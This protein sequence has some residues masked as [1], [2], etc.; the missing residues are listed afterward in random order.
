MAHPVYVVEQFVCQFLAQWHH[1]L[2]PMLTIDTKTNGSIAVSYNC[3]VPFLTPQLNNDKHDESRK[4]RSGRR[5]RLRRRKQRTSKFKENLNNDALSSQA[6]PSSVEADIST[7]PVPFSLSPRSETADQ[8]A[9]ANEDISSLGKPAA[10]CEVDSQGSSTENEAITKFGSDNSNTQVPINCI[11][12]EEGCTNLVSKYFNMYTAICRHCSDLLETKLMTSPY[13][14]DLC[15]CCHQH[16]EGSK[17]SL[18]AECL[19]EIYRDGYAESPWGS[20]HLD[21]DNGKIV[22][23]SLSFDYWP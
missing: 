22:C 13:P 6:A 10:E 15:P 4:S 20:W 14:H 3:T 23:I 19:E 17:L 8:R 7:L 5:S 21:R 11:M 1:G 9:I 18:C 12:F 2:Q 16:V